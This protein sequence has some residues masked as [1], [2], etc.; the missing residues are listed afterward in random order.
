MHRLLTMS[1]V[2]L[3]MIIQTGCG[4]S[5]SEPEK[6]EYNYSFDN[7]L[8]DWNVRGIDLMVGGEEVDWSITHTSEPS[9][10]SSGAA[11]FYLENNTDAGKIWLERSFIL[12]PNQSYV[13]EVDFAFGTSDYGDINLWTIISGAHTT[14]PETHEELTYRGKTG[15]DQGES[16]GL[17][18]LNKEHAF[19]AESNSDGELFVTVGVW[20]TYEVPR[21]YYIDELEISFQ[22]E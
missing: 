13:V 11:E 16:A 2:I 22:P 10:N 19:I 8:N 4:I 3:G 21:T 5:D 6:T 18:W 15:H 12:E 14:P 9:Y 7:G 1:V 17:V 20:G